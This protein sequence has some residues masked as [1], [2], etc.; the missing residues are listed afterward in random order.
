MIHI[1]NIGFEYEGCMRLRELPF[2]GELGEE[3]AGELTIRKRKRIYADGLALFGYLK[4]RLKLEEG[5]SVLAWGCGGAEILT[6]SLAVSMLGASLTLASEEPASTE[7]YELI[8]APR[9]SGDGAY[10]ST[11][12][13]AALILGE[14]S[15]S[16]RVTDGFSPRAA[17][18]GFISKANERELYESY[19]EKTLMTAGAEYISASSLLPTDKQLSVLPP[20]SREGFIFGL[21]APSMIGADSYC[22]LPS[23][24]LFERIRAA[25]P[26]RLLCYPSVAQ[27]SEDIAD[28]GRLSSVTVIGDLPASVSEALL[29]RGVY[30]LSVLSFPGC[31]LAGYRDGRDES[32]VWRLPSSLRADMC[33]VS[34]G[35]VGSLTFRGSI[36]ASG[37][38]DDSCKPWKYRSEPDGSVSLISDLYGFALKKQRFFVKGRVN[39]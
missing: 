6:I 17:T 3:E 31:P 18:F 14:R 15:T 11:D 27:G 35:G 39:F 1:G 22:S 16:A 29:D 36:V 25:S 21:L 8:I 12:E 26:T 7:G 33:N 2:G 28:L 19:E 20:S 13:L 30:H 10:V 34:A 38:P 5:T 24:T 23:P 9:Y 4:N 37:S 32:G